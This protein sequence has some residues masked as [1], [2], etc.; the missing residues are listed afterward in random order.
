MQFCS[1]LYVRMF[2]IDQEY[3]ENSSA[4]PNHLALP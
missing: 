4:L 3:D 2:K 1:L